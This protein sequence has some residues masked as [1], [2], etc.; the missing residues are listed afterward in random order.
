MFNSLIADLY[1]Y[2]LGASIGAAIVKIAIV[3]IVIFAIIGLIA[4]IRFLASRGKKKQKDPYKEW[5]KTGK[6]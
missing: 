1:F 3:V 4:T 5:L 6:F 2:S